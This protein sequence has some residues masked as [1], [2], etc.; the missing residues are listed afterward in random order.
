MPPTRAGRRA[1]DQR[2]HIL[3]CCSSEPAQG[4]EPTSAPPGARSRRRPWPSSGNRCSHARRT[5][6]GLTKRFSARRA[7]RQGRRAS[8]A[9]TNSESRTRNASTPTLASV[10]PPRRLRASPGPARDC[11]QVAARQQRCDRRAPDQIVDARGSTSDHAPIETG[12][13][14]TGPC[15]GQARRVAEQIVDR[16]PPGDRAQGQEMA[17]QPQRR[18]AD[19]RSREGGENQRKHKPDPRRIHRRRRQP[20]GRIRRNAD[21]RR[22]PDRHH[23]ADAG[24]QHESKRASA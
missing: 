3:E 6:A 8:A 15:D 10:L 16:Q 24:E 4:A 7:S 13:I 23:A 21:E 19:R 5:G 20:R 9:M 2:Q 1:R 22:L 18:D 11:E 12:G 14:P 17:A